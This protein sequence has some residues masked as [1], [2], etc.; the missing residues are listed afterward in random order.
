M[1][2][3]SLETEVTTATGSR[4]PAAPAPPSLEPWGSQAWA[5]SL[6]AMELFALAAPAYPL[7]SLRRNLAKSLP[8]W[9]RKADIPL[10]RPEPHVRSWPKTAVLTT[11]HIK[12]SLDTS[13][14]VLGTGKEVLIAPLLRVYSLSVLG[15]RKCHLLPP[16]CCSAELWG[17]RKDEG[18]PTPS[19]PTDFQGS[20]LL[21][22]V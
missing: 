22:G 1:E 17:Y 16:Q 6:P 4:T 20:H 5:W 7:E 21:Q 10:A 19:A 2:R 13:G 18:N 3:N 12:A 8:A 14:H 9:T 15:R 11:E